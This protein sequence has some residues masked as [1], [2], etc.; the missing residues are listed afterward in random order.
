MADEGNA[1]IETLH[2][3]LYAGKLRIHLRSD[4]PFVPHMTVGASRDQQTAE[5]LAKALDI[6]RIVRGTL[7]SFDLIDVG[8]VRVATLATYTFGN[9]A[10]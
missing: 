3:R 9:G 10:E 2:D 4:V 8:Q 5:K 6:G 7:A 1:Q